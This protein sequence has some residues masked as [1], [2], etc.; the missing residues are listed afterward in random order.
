MR[1]RLLPMA[2]LA[3][4]LAA[5]EPAELGSAQQELNDCLPAYTFAPVAMPPI[6]PWTGVVP[7]GSGTTVFVFGRDSQNPGWYVA[8]QVEHTTRKIPWARSIPAGKLGEFVDQAELAGIIIRYPPQPNPPPPIVDGADLLE[9]AFRAQQA[10]ANAI[11]IMI[12][13]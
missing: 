11:E 3:L 8:W 12:T 10:E 6:K 7:P 4:A 9:L 5:C 1:L 13:N 2:G